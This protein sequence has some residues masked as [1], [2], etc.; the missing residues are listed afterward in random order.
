M[1]K[2]FA[3]VL[4][5][6]LL[7]C[8]GI[9][10]QLVGVSAAEAE[11]YSAS[12]WMP[13]NYVLAE[14][15]GSSQKKTN[16]R[17]DLSYE[18]NTLKVTGATSKG[19]VGV[20]F[21]PQINLSDFSMEM[22]LD[23]WQANST[24]K[25]YGINLLDKGEKTDIYNEVPFYSKHSESWSN[26]YG[27]GT[28]FAFRTFSQTGTNSRP[29]V[30]Q[31]QFNNIGIVH[32][33]DAEGNYNPDAGK[34]SDGTLGWSGYLSTIQLCD[35]NWEPLTNYN[36]IKITSK[37]ITHENGQKG[38]AF[39]I[40]DGYWIRTE[41]SINWAEIE[42]DADLFA[43]LDINV[44]G[45]LDDGEKA[46]WQ[47]GPAY[48]ATIGGT[49]FSSF[50]PY[51]NWGDPLH[52]LYNFNKLLTDSG[53]RLYLSAMYKDAFNMPEGENAQFTIKTVNGKNTTKSETT[54]L[55]T[56]KV[57]ASGDITATLKAEN[58]YAGVYPSMVN[59][60]ITGETDAKKYSK[61]LEKIEA[62]KSELGTKNYECVNFF[63][64]VT[65]SSS[66]KT[67]SLIAPIDV[68]MNLNGK[69]NFKLYKITGTD[70]DEVTVTETDGK[71][72]FSVKD[73]ASIYVMYYSA[74]GSGSTVGCGGCNSVVGTNPT[75]TMGVF[76]IITA[77]LGFVILRLKKTSK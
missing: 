43:Q 34:Y 33:W 9:S 64:E 77:A 62:K 15:F 28:L 23:K 2:L 5:V 30:L 35:T 57:I 29:G 51:I 63:G 40:N 13:H 74:G 26:D 67:V 18:N 17:T 32:S 4:I 11:S 22:S 48:K 14:G 58:L 25:W 76:I 16:I 3:S 38:Y 54:S 69:T 41:D 42:A 37:E 71:A 72:K 49:E 47:C 75:L 24:D 56:E 1:K 27:A 10:S 36:K 46:L 68:T 60:L 73:S 7:V 66:P 6:A 65:V 61:V 45:T 31:I 53:K 8:A 39:D 12:D 20:T 44:D 55:N 70:L 21:L 52:S 50:V 19:G 59:K